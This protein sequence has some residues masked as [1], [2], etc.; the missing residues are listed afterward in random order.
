MKIDIVGNRDNCGPGCD[1]FIAKW[2]AWTKV[3]EGQ[4]MA[5][6][7]IDP[8][9]YDNLESDTR[10]MIRKA[11]KRGY[12]FGYFDYNSFLYD[13]Y[14]IN[15]SKEVRQGKVMS[16]SY[17]EYPT[18]IGVDQSRCDLHRYVRIGGF[19]DSRLLAYCAVAVLNEAA[20]LNTI[21]G[22]ADALTDGVMNG[23]INSVVDKFVYNSTAVKYLNYLTMRSATKD[24]EAFK[25]RAGFQPY[26]VFFSV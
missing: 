1:A 24:L 18:A 15:T 19:K 26:E 5:I 9:Y 12:T 25:R 17:L 3:Y 4:E 10:Y 13:I 8:F 11:S 16:Q 7:K 6:L 22:H 2:S 21:I 20:I 14:Q 23:L